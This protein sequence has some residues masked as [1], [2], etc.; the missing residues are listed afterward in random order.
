M[1]WH[2]ISYIRTTITWVAV[3]FETV[4]STFDIDWFG[5]YIMR[6]AHRLFPFSCCSPIDTFHI[7]HLLL[8]HRCLHTVKKAAL[9][10]WLFI[11]SIFVWIRRFQPHRLFFNHSQLRVVSSFAC[12][13]SCIQML[14]IG[15]LLLNCH[16]H[17][18]LGHYTLAILDL[19][20]HRCL[21]IGLQRRE[22]LL[23]GQLCRFRLNLESWL[24]LLHR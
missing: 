11:L 22:L 5:D 2:R 6:L 10:R 9:L 1:L 16:H 19:W 18:L 3:E 21:I 24:R 8:H 12:C 23:L 20:W 13:S 14:I 7:L 4:L 15:I 17:W